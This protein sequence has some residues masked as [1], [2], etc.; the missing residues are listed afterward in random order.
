M[1]FSGIPPLSLASY[2]LVDPLSSGSHL[3][4]LPQLSTDIHTHTHT[5]ANLESPEIGR[6]VKADFGVEGEESP[7]F[8]YSGDF[9]KM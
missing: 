7:N 6:F 2:S 5:L 4:S 9:L 8:L 3:I 1:K